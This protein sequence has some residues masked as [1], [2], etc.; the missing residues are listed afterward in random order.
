LHKLVLRKV[1]KLARNKVVKVEATASSFAR[2]LIAKVTAENRKVSVGSLQN[3]ERKEVLKILYE[4]EFEV[5]YCR[6]TG[7][8][9]G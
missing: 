9:I 1:R 6:K 7:Y 4:S 3:F 5:T 8:W 2:E